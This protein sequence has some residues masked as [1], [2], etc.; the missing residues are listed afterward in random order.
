MVS[1]RA[2]S[3]QSHDAALIRRQL[4]WLVF[5][6]A[7]GVLLLAAVALTALVKIRINGPLYRS[8]ALS[9]NLIAD[10]EPPSQSLLEPALLCNRLVDAQDQESRL[11]VE[12]RLKAFQHNYDSRYASYMA[13]A[14]E[15]TLKGMM[16]GTAY[17]TAQQYFQLADQ[18]S[19]LV[20]RGRGDEARNLLHATMNPLYRRHAAAVDQIV[21]RAN[22]EARDA[23]SLAARSVRNY[24]VAVVAIGILIVICVATLSW[25]VARG[26]SE[27]ALSLAQSEESLSDSEELYRS[28]F[29]Q[30]AIGILHVSFKGE[31]LRCNARFAEIIGYSL[32]EIRGKTIQEI[33][34]PEYHPQSE[35]IFQE[36]VAG[37]SIR[38]GL[39]K[40]YLRKDGTSTWVR[41]TTSI[42]RDGN[43]EAV[44]FV[45][46]VQD[47]NEH[48]AAEGRLTDAMNA[49]QINES[50]YRTV[51]Q[52][53]RDG[54][55]ITN[56]ADGS[57]T[58]VNQ[59]FLDLAG[60]QREEV[61]GRSS[62][63][64][65]LWVDLKERENLLQLLRQNSNFRDE[66][67]MLRKRS[68]ELFSALMSGSI[69]EIDGIPCA[70]TVTRDISDAKA[71]EDKIRDLAFYDRVTRIPNR[72]LLLDRLQQAVSGDSRN[73]DMKAVLFVD[74]DVFKTLNETLGH[75]IGDLLL[76]AVAQRL[77][78][79]V[80]EADTVARFGADEFV[81]VLEG[82]SEVSEEAA[83]AAGDV[84]RKILVAVGEPYI[85]A[86]H[87]CHMTAS[88]GVTVFGDARVSPNEVL[89]QADI[90]MS[91][92]K[93]AG[94]NGIRFFAPSLQA[95]V[96]ARAALKEDLSQA[97]QANQFLLYYQPQVDANG[98]IGAEALIRWQHPVRGLVAPDEF[99]PLAEETGLILSLGDLALKMA[100]LQIAAWTDR[101]LLANLQ[102]AVN[103][104]ARQFA[105][106]D[107]VEHT[108]AILAQTRVNPKNLKLELTESMLASDMTG[109]IAKMT[110]LKS[111]GLS[112]SLDDFGTG[113]SSLSYLKT[114][115]LDQ[116]KIDRAFVQDI[117][118]D[119]ASAAIA[120]TIVSLGRAMGL[121]V[122]A[123]GVESEEQRRFLASFGAH[124]FQ[125]YLYSR[126][127]PLEEFERLWLGP[128]KRM[129]ALP[130]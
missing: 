80:H 127:L 23:E 95:A 32:E 26:V 4:R 28:T 39:D 27:Q 69:I 31:I 25:L 92:A 1:S 122:V 5:I 68:G 119:V 44:H 17:A 9:N 129:T 108:L 65:G 21:V 61:I 130:N 110:E 15:G 124:S 82:L 7:C 67:V 8:I 33:T 120:Q 101:N 72:R 35:E 76:H 63:Q 118:E 121:S 41:R 81:V 57:L 77:M 37:E 62:E 75:Q 40:Q 107:F 50:R 51:F 46:F 14:P 24:T 42:Q 89:Q 70:L 117:L 83:A 12:G 6:G 86:G 56:L 84:G 85:L 93:N 48:K 105:Q 53:S 38:S 13:R 66:K 113:Y 19:A 52:T 11:R 43:G 60:Y 55:G 115:P 104:S 112:F 99:I 109:V 125:G 49:L 64:L 22:E 45:T 111:H 100:C 97:I 71:A 103:I 54:L 29:D 98:L 18:L 10:Y 59:A 126:P 116:L 78:A 74:L 87:E 102:I 114:L 123:E 30:A 2:V 73:S 47:M 128:G 90:A 34:P 91:Q 36:L 16:R 58:E 88:I 96:N 79:C 106:P 94:G 20:N 3:A